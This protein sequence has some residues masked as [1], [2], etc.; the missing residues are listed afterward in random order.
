M[1]IQT[2]EEYEKCMEE[3]RSVAFHI[4]ATSRAEELSDAL[5]DYEEKHFRIDKPSEE[6]MAEFR[7]DQE[8]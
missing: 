4:E 1:I 6:A 2:F 7:K 3:W 8:S 5:W